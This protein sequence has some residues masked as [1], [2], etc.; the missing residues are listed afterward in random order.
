MDGININ[1]NG[2]VFHSELILYRD[3]V[4][5]GSVSLDS[6]VT[7]YMTSATQVGI[8]T[9]GWYFACCKY[10]GFRLS[11]YIIELRNGTNYISSD[12]IPIL[13]SY[14]D[15]E[16]RFISIDGFS[17]PNEIASGNNQ[18]YDDI[19][20]YNRAISFDEMVLLGSQRGI[21]YTPKQ[22]IYVPYTQSTIPQIVF[23][24]KNLILGCSY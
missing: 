22:K 12:R 23:K 13:T 7:E 4:F 21:A 19:R 20:I 18:R 24:G 17:I 14:Y 16:G 10:D 1:C 3:N 5:D 11:N 2:G 15:F 9:D 8:Y 6:N